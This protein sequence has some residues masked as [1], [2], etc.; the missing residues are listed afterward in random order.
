MWWSAQSIAAAAA[1]AAMA[2]LRTA[3]P[4]TEAASDEVGACAANGKAQAVGR[5]N[6]LASFTTANEAGPTA[7]VS[8]AQLIRYTASASAGRTTI[9]EA[10]Q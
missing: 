2:S 6:C 3:P 8:L 10:V 1:A 9:D 7:Q 4:K 5:C